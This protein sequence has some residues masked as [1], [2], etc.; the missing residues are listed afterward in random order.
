MWHRPLPKDL[1]EQL[2]QMWTEHA[3]PQAAWPGD[4]GP[5]QAHELMKRARNHSKGSAGPDGIS[6]ENLADMPVQWWSMLAQLLQLWTAQNKFPASWREAR[7]VLIPKDEVTGVAAE[8]ARLRPITVLNATYRVVAATWTARACVRDW[9]PQ[10]CPPYFHGGIAGRNA[11]QALRH[12]EAAWDE[13][14]ILISFDFEKCFDNVAPALALDNLRRHG[15][16]ENFLKV[17]AWTWLAQRRW[18]QYGSFVHP[19]PQHVSASLPQGCPASPL[20][21]TALLLA[22]ATHLQ[23]LMGTELCQ[24]IFVDDRTAVTRSADDTERVITFWASAAKALGL[25]ENQGKLKVVT[26]SDRQRRLLQA[27]GIQPSTEANVLGTPFR[28]DGALEVAGS[29]LDKFQALL[30][31]LGCLPVVSSVKH[32][33]YRSV[34]IPQLLWGFWWS[35][36]SAADLQDQQKLTT[37]VKRAL[38]VVQ[39]GS[40]ELWLLLAGHWMDVGFALRL[41]SASAFFAADAFWRGQGRQLVTGRWGR[42]VGSLLQELQFTRTGAHAWQHAGAGAFDLSTGDAA[43]RAKA[44]H[45]MREAWRRQCYASF[46]RGQRHELADLV[47]DDEGYSETVLKAAIK[48]YNGT[49]NEE[50]HV[51]L[52]GCVSEEQ[53]ARMH[54]LPPQGDESFLLQCTLCGRAGVPNWWHAAWCCPCFTSSRP[55]TPASSWAWR[56]GWPLR[57]ERHADVRARLRHLGLVRAAVRDRFGF[58]PPGRRQVGET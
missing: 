27:K 11:W 41:A 10:V 40:R 19:E 50:R 34:I 32:S 54:K 36:C 7:M 3:P 15:C 21:L 24:S 17:V 25:Q 31:R 26:R 29:R 30:R 9:L 44:R 56:L 39:Q 45:L 23:S 49:S 6:A 58:R 14:A 52:G 48:L 37:N 22:P 8:V 12:I 4:Q 51:M 47:P 33:L 46:L 1:H 53:Y 43:A 2:D 5:L 38:D 20:A 16:P 35:P 28:E 42:A 18:I 57:G 13:E 55:T